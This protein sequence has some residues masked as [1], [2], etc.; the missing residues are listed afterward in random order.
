[1]GCNAGRVLSCLNGREFVNEV[2]MYRTGVKGKT[3]SDGIL[4]VFL[5]FKFVLKFIRLSF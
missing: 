4:F 1:M 3:C 5:Y 2:C